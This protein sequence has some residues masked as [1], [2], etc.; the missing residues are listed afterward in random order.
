MQ[1]LDH[2]DKLKIFTAV[3]EAG[4]INGAAKTLGLTQPSITR[5]IQVLED[6]AGFAL[7]SRNRSGVSLTE[8]GKIFFDSSVRILK[9]AVDAAQRGARYQEEMAGEIRIGTYESLA[10]YLWPDFL[11][12]AEK[13]FP[14]LSISL[15]SNSQEGHSRE[16]NNGQL[17]LLVDAEP[18]AQLGLTLWPLYGDRF[19][20]F[21]AKKMEV[22]PESASELTLLSVRGVFDE[23][24][25]TL[26]AHLSRRGYRF[27]REF[28][29]DSFPTV[30]RM[31]EKGL[32]LAILPKRLAAESSLL[33][34]RVE[35]F[36]REG[37]GPHRIYA[38]VSTHRENDKRVKKLI[39]FLKASL[40]G[41]S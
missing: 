16:L 11:L 1:I 2:L 10:D 5:A 38:T 24:D 3:A 36:P 19:G 41:K 29:L 8:G 9:E 37:F 30:R 32:G 20:F 4:T 21:A 34:A 13:E 7:F 18:R 15:K 31:A 39:S 27:R 22:N 17:D 14:H 26:E 40:A 35:G 6:A 33:P 12:A 28:V 23:E 25:V